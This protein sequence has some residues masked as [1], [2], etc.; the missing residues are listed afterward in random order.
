MS[1][2]HKNRPCGN[3]E[4]GISTGF[5]DELTFGSGELSDWGY[6][7]HPCWT[8]ASAYKSQHPN[9][10]VWPNSYSKADA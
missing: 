2:I 5:S 3:P 6:W 1:P 4:C 8:C 9:E 10:L 7:E